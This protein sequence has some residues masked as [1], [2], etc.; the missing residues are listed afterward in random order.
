MKTTKMSQATEVFNAYFGRGYSRKVIIQEFV[1]T[2]GL[3]QKGAS[4]YYQKLRAAVRDQ[5]DVDV[6]AIADRLPRMIPVTTMTNKQLVETYNQFGTNEA[7]GKVN[8][9]EN[10]QVGLRR[11]TTLLDSLNIRYV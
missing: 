6:K 1:S 11:V 7:G 10:R 2:V 3:T 8:R 4:T 5:V 9:F